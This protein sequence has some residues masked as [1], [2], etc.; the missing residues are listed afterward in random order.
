MS[1]SFWPRSPPPRRSPTG[2]NATRVARCPRGGRRRPWSPA[3]PP[4]A[5]RRRP[6]RGRRRRASSDWTAAAEG[7]LR[8]ALRD[9]RRRLAGDGVRDP[10][11]DGDE[12]HEDDQ[13]DH[14]PAAN[15]VAA[16][17]S[18]A[19]GADWPGLCACRRPSYNAR[20]PAASRGR[21]RLTR[22]RKFGRP[23]TRTASTSAR[24]RRH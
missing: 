10:D 24:R 22:T 20:A 19:A 16:A 8:G 21:R 6:R 7:R 11:G 14:T 23:E 13:R 18:A 15:L 4:A 3:A 9:A 1:A 12:G 17:G 5:A 2:V